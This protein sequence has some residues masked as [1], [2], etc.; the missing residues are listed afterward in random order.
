MGVLIS[1]AKKEGYAYPSNEMLATT[2]KTSTSTIGRMLSKLETDKFINREIIRDNHGQVTERKIYILSSLV[3]RPI[4]KNDDTLHS[5][6][7]T[8]LSPN[9]VIPY[10]QIQV[11]N[12]KTSL[13]KNNSKG[14]KRE[15]E[16]AF[17]ILFE[18][19]KKRGNRTRALKAFL[20]LSKTDMRAIWNHTPIYLDAHIKAGKLDFL[21]HFSTYINGKYW[22]DELPY[23]DYK[24]DLTK[25]L[26]DW[27]E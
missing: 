20:R 22:L 10:T 2:L 19:L 14:D 6:L 4:P 1:L 9:M 8:P 21:P 23:Q 26:I 18:K 25:T 27:N 5:D 16:A 13:V 17:D 3:N 7:V 15:F 24:K 12:N 11:L